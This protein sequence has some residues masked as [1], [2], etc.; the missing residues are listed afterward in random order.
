QASS[1]AETPEQQDS[2]Q[3]K[4]SAGIRAT[5][6]E[7]VEEAEEHHRPLCCTCT[8]AFLKGDCCGCWRWLKQQFHTFITNPFFD[9]VIIIC[10]IVS[11]IFTAMEHYPM[12][13][14]F[15][16]TLVIAE[17]VFRVIFAAEMIIKLVALGLHGYFQVRWHIFDFILVIISLVQLGLADVEG[18]SLLHS[19]LP[20]SITSPSLSSSSS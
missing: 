15:M 9:L 7:Y 14:E 11:T 1:R 18:L 8:D 19:F 16:E 4:K 12:M 6:Q 13:E 3:K 2:L 5:K 17:L 10:I 20:V